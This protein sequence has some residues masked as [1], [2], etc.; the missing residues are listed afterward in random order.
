MSDWDKIRIGRGN[1]GRVIAFR[2]GPGLNLLKSLEEI[3]RRENIGSGVILSGAGSLRQVTLRNVRLF[4]DKFPVMDRNR[5]YTPKKE[6][7]ELLSLSGN[8]AR[9]GDEVY[10]HCHIT[11]SSGLDDG[12]AYG[13]HLIEDCEVFSYCEIVIA[14]ITGLEMKRGTDPETH[15]PELFFT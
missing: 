13:G 11:V 1:L 5:I 12:R 7:L 3:A 15:G 9:K 10:I 6:P 14:E 4:P 2:L 8:I